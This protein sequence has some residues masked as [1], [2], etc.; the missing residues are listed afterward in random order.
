MDREFWGESRRLVRR[1]VA[2]TWD[3][4]AQ[5]EPLLPSSSAEVQPLLWLFAAGGRTVLWNIERWNCETVLE[6]PKLSAPRKA[7]LVLRALAMRRFTGYRPGLPG[8]SQWIVDPEPDPEAGR[9]PRPVSSAD[10]TADTAPH[11]SAELPA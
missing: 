10:A 9:Y 8:P 1:L 6:R 7:A 11:A 5:A 2:R 4:Y 3:V